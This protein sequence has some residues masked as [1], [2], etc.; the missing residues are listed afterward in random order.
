[1]FENLL[2]NLT[3]FFTEG[4]FITEYLTFFI[5]LFAILAG[6]RLPNFFKDLFDNII[7]KFI[8]LFFVFY[9][10]KNN[11]RL[12]LMLSL[13]YQLIMTRIKFN[14]NFEKFDNRFP[15][16]KQKDILL[17]EKFSDKKFSFI[18]SDNLLQKYCNN[19]D[20]IICCQY[21][22]IRMK[23]DK[24]FDPE[25]VKKELKDKKEEYQKNLDDKVLDEL[26]ILKSNYTQLKKCF[27]KE[28]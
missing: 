15:H 5:F 20:D 10:S 6:P 21:T 26:T 22:R 12:A 28:F 1:M 8:F 13:F 7:F 17:K 9:K 4:D 23:D 27:P 2:S 14:Q 25:F 24:V 19:N 11:I 18:D 16:F 3:S